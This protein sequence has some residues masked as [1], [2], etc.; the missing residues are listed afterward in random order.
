M[1]SELINVCL[2]LGF[3]PCA[4]LLAAL[5]SSFPN[6]SKVSPASRDAD[7]KDRE[8]AQCIGG[9]WCQELGVEWWQDESKDGTGSKDPRQQNIWYKPKPMLENAGGFAWRMDKLN[10]GHF[11]QPRSLKNRDKCFCPGC[12]WG[13]AS[14]RKGSPSIWPGLQKPQVGGNQAQIS[15]LHPPKVMSPIAVLQWISRKSKLSGF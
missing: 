5:F 12:L 14:E 4:F 3:H 1:F 11:S 7:S 13:C 8:H 6:E 15:L 10:V 2:S 9:L